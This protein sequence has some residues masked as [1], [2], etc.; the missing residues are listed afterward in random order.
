MAESSDSECLDHKLRQE[1]QQCVEQLTTSGKPVL[2]VDTMKKFKSICKKSDMYVKEA[3]H[4]LMTQL[5]KEHS[6]IRLSTF[7]MIDELFNRSHVFRELLLSDLQSYMELTVEI[8]FDQPLP[9]PKASANTLKTSALRAIQQWNDKFGEAYKKLSLGINFL[10][11]C[12]KVDFNGIRARGEAEQRRERERAER[13]QR[14]NQDRVNKVLREIEETLPDI[15]TCLTEVENCFAILL[16][17]PE[18]FFLGIES[19]ENDKEAHV[20]STNTENQQKSKTHTQKCGHCGITDLISTSGD[21]EECSKNRNDSDNGTVVVGK[22][23]NQ[24]KNDTEVKCKMKDKSGKE[25]KT[26]IDENQDSEEKIENEPK[27]IQ[28]S[29]RD[30]TS[31]EGK[32]SDSQTVEKSETEDQ[33]GRDSSDEDSDDSDD[34][35]LEEVG[36]FVQEHGLRNHQY[37]IAIDIQSGPVKLEENEDNLPLLTTLKD[38]YRLISTKHQP[39]V[40]RWL[41]VLSKHGGK[42]DDIKRVIDLKSQLQQTKNQFYDL[43][44]VPLEEQT[45]NGDDDSDDEFEDVP[46]KEGF[47]EDIPEHLKRDL[48]SGSASTSKKSSSSSSK[49]PTATVTSAS[50]KPSTSG[51]GAKR[52]FVKASWSIQNEL[53]E[54]DEEDPTAMIANLKR[55]KAE[56]ESKS[57]TKPATDETSKGMYITSS[58]KDKL[59]SS[60]PVVPFGVD[61]EHWENPDKIQAPEIVKYDSLHRFWTASDVEHCKTDTSS[62]GELT[63]RAIP[64]VG[65]FEPVK[66]KCRAP[67]PNGSLCERMDRIKCPFHGKI[68]ARDEYG[69]AANAEDQDKP[70]TST[71][72]LLEEGLSDWQDPELQADIEAA[73]GVDL[74]SKKGKGKGKGKKKKEP[75]YPNLTDINIVENTSRT[76]LEK[77]VLNKSALKRVNNV[78][79]N[80]AYKRIRDRFGNQFNYSLN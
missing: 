32:E 62:I 47:E 42:E 52:T 33:T 76:R 14:I 20:C 36:E 30:E 79:D 64:F 25:L 8:D 72:G 73:L 56:A 69:V 75:K 71:Q 54:H 80:L 53:L 78:M 34:D 9:P 61:L 41:Q 40:T 5:E 13:Q 22:D 60:A 57:S 77:R 48:G 31:V 44:V 65:K 18:N 50:V 39:S 11:K 3:Y 49:K 7:Q 38:H 2:N 29:L 19:S 16:P 67:L 15:K 74:Y 55:I 24:P 10:Q 21:C 4:M 59:L 35:D 51:I 63:K 26:K 1:M 37:S 27:N 68:I 70:S 66:W 43:K 6:E 45:K 58:R 28:D 46:E 17:T 12:K 23:S